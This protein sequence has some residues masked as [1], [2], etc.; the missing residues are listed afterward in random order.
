[1][2]RVA[3]ILG[4][5]LVAGAVAIGGL[6]WWRGVAEKAALNRAIVAAERALA[7][8]R[9]AEARAVLE[10]QARRR[11]RPAEPEAARRWVALEFGAA[12]GLRDFATLE[13]LA[14][15]DPALAGTDE[16]AALWLWRMRRAEGDAAGAEAVRALWRGREKKPVLWRCAELDAEVLAGRLDAVREVLANLPAD[17]AQAVPL[18]LRRAIYSAD[19][20]ERMRALDEAYRRDPAS[21]DT[22]ALRA[23]ML[24][25]AGQAAYARVDYVAALVADPKNPLRRDELASFYLRQGDLG[26]AVDTW[27]EGL[28]ERSPD[29]QWVRAVFWGRVLGRVA[30]PAAAKLPE[31]RKKR[32]A[33]W[34]STLPEG[35]FWDEAGYAA[36]SLSGAHA[37]REPAVFWLR[38]LERLRAGDWAA[39]GEGLAVAPR[40]AVAV[41]PVLHAALRLTAATRAGAEPA[42]TGLAWSDVTGPGAHRWWTV[43]A[44]ARRGDETAASEFAAVARGPVAASATLLAAGWTGPALALAD[45]EETRRE[46]TPGWVRYGLL[47]ARRVTRGAADALAW[48]A[49]LPPYPET[50]YA[51]AALR[52]ANGGA[53]EAEPVLGRLAV[54]ADDLGFAAG[55]LLATRWLEQG[56]VAEAE[57]LVKAAPALVATPQGAGLLA[58]AALARGDGAAAAAI[59]GP[60]AETSL[61]AGA[62]VA[63]AAFAAGDLARAR[64]LTEL[65]LEREPDNLALRA[66]LELI[67]KAEQTKGAGR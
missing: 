51:L 10:D 4:L 18:L 62:Y 66:N 47:E 57:A 22:R 59:F 32:F 28:D 38:T 3:W 17:E 19:A 49:G 50:D 58:R 30:P 34:L 55:W 35:V 25:R 46:T 5:L 61:E 56:M 23:T 16:A 21:A 48:G 15:R 31:A 2:K 8:E 13:A 12:G 27:A 40:A 26:A 52:L 43:A 36:L 67:A 42:Q 54:R 53:A 9:W 39:A 65:W 41:A 6:W 44:A 11:G 64:A 14:A 24:E 29:F 20:A 60:L 33:G 1:M 45:A 63:R 7:G 37:E